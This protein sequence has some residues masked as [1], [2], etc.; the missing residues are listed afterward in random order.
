ML[1]LNRL[2]VKQLLLEKQTPEILKS[3]C[4]HPVG[5]GKGPLGGYTF[6]GYILNLVIFNAR[7]SSRVQKCL[8]DPK[9]IN[10]FVEQP[11]K[12]KDLNITFRKEDCD[13]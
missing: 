3:N 5:L 13:V 6:G 2:F 9:C 12:R 1:L 7:L 11:L 10:I 8:S 4:S